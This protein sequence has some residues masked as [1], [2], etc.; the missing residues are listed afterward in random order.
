MKLINTLSGLSGCNIFLFEKN[1]EFIV[2]KVSK[3]VLYNER[4]I[5]QIVKQ[6][7]FNHPIIKTPKI[8]YTGYSNDLFFCDMEYV[9]GITFSDFISTYPFKVSRKYFETICKFIIE[10]NVVIREINKDFFLKKIDEINHKVR[11]DD[12]VLSELNKN[13][14]HNLYECSIHGDLTFEN[15]IISNDGHIYF[16]DF[17]DSFIND[18]FIDIS[19]INQEL[20]LF[21]SCRSGVPNLN[22]KIKYNKLKILF[23]KHILNHVDEDSV[24][25]YNLLTLIRILP[26]SS[27]YEKKIIEKELKYE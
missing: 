20:N 17:L 27:E 10:K 24:S 3:D 2:R 6:K 25:F 18:F 15:I 12:R 21:W 7:D 13:I 8:H 23:K 26:Y 5:T 16:I 9:D 19:K 14:P 22:T 4:L 11:L 1:N